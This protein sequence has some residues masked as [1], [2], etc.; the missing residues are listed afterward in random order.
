MVIAESGDAVLTPTIGAAAR[1][2]VRQIIPSTSPGAVVLAYRPPLSL[3]EIRTPRAPV[4]LACFVVRQSLFLGG[5]R[6]S[7]FQPGTGLLPPA[8]PSGTILR[9]QRTD[10]ARA[11]VPVRVLPRTRAYAY[12]AKV[13]QN[14]PHARHLVSWF[15]N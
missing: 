4:L 13:S 15:S 14:R 8:T 2:V 1:V 11:A 9:R 3:G 7:S 10:T 12:W 6:R 5:H